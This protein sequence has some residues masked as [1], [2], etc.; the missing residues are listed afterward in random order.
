MRFQFIKLMRAPGAYIK[1]VWATI[2]FSIVTYMHDGSVTTTAYYAL[3]FMLLL[4]VG[5]V[6][7]V[8]FLIRRE[9]VRRKIS[10]GVSADPAPRHAFRRIGV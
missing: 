10:D 7:G 2:V 3:C 5:Y 6:A 8:L 9:A 4:Q 1:M